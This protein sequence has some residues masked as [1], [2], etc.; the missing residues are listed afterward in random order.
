MIGLGKSE[1]P[2]NF[3]EFHDFLLS[4]KRVLNAEAT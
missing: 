1:F 2:L 4:K 3:F